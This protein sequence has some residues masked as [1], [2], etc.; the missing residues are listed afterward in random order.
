MNIILVAE[1]DVVAKQWARTAGFTMPVITVTPFAGATQILGMT[2][3]L[4]ISL[5][6]W[7]HSPGAAGLDTALQAA[8]RKSP[9]AVPWLEVES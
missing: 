1:S 6:R 2:P 3:D 4:V 9:H 5:G 8:I 7:R